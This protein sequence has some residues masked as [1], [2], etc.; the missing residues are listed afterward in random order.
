MFILYIYI[1]T[2]CNGGKGGW[3]C[4]SII[5]INIKMLIQMFY[6]LLF[7]LF[8]TYHTDYKSYNMVSVRGVNY[9]SICFLSHGCATVDYS[10]NTVN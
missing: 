6:I 2:T 5:V 10:T 8:L 1:Y 9:D 7:L 3:V 4:E